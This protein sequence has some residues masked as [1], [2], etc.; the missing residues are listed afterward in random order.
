MSSLTPDD[1]CTQ[2]RLWPTT[3]AVL[4]GTAM[5]IACLPKEDDDDDE[6]DGDSSS[7][8]YRYGSSYSDTEDAAGFG[9][10]DVTVELH[11]EGLRLRLVDAP[12]AFDFG[13]VQTAGCT[14]D[15]W[16]AE[17]CL[18][19]AH[20]VSV[21]HD[22]GTT[23]VVLDRVSGTDVLEASRT[24]RTSSALAEQLTFLLDDGATCYTWGHAPAQVAELLGC[25]IW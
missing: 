4:L 20:G 2:D 6:R 15:C 10:E 13:V 25:T 12:A 19:S 3:L 21:C 8:S 17:S 11:A 16:T 1:R 24:T 18:P 7:Y 22:A 5:A 9:P 14:D 23:G